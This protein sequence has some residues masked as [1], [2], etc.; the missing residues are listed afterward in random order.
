MRGG[1]RGGE[2]GR[3]GEWERGEERR[4]VMKGEGRERKG[5]P[6]EGKE[7]KE[8][9]RKGRKGKGGFMHFFQGDGNAIS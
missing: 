5:E 2:R 1:E 3:R 7:R 4:D 8:R 9:E 6:G